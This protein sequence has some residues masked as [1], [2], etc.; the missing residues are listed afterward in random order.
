VELPAD[1]DVSDL[2]ACVAEAR[3][4]GVCTAFFT[5]AFCGRVDH[6]LAALGT[7]LRAADLRARVR[8]PGWDGWALDGEMM[9]AAEVY[10][11]VGATFS[12]VAPG[13][14]DGV[15][16]TGGSYPLTG[17]RLDAMSSFGVGNTVAESPIVVSVRSGSMLI[18]AARDL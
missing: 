7:V 12:V 8:E 3:S 18:I 2:E 16:I 15:T 17:A 4:E 9:P 13:G 11:P 5:A 1:K 14:A 10:L 6:T